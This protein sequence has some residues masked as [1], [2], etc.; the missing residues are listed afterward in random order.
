MILYI[1]ECLEGGVFRTEKAK[2]RG[3]YLCVVCG[4]LEV[5]K[6]KVKVGPIVKISPVM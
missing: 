3:P 6:V 1:R 4:L 5:V 2:R